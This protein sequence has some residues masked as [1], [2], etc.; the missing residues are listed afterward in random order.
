MVR[1]ENNKPDVT[2]RS[3]KNI[4]F[5]RW[6]PYAEGYSTDFVKALINENSFAEGY[7]YE[8]FAGTGTTI[9]ASDQLGY[10][11]FYSEIN[12][13]LRFLIDTKVAVQSLSKEKRILLCQQLCEHDDIFVRSSHCEKDV[14]L[15]KT[16]KLV[17]GNSTYFPK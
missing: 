10:S 5:Q 2:F 1:A 14:E 17:F 13:V 7:I 15:E 16:Y 3:S 9:F 8:P 11:T 4:P 12:P 6:Y